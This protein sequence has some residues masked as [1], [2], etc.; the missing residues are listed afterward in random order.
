MMVSPRCAAV[1]ATY[2]FGRRE[3][4]PLPSLYQACIDLHSLQASTD[5]LGA[6]VTKQS[7]YIWVIVQRKQPSQMNVRER[8]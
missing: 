5:M 2:V 3:Q 4:V 7:S 6:L 8:P 1:H